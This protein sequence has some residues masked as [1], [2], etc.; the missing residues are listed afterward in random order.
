MNPF[1]TET[2]AELCLR[3]GHRGEGLAIYRRLVASAADPPTRHRLGTRLASLEADPRVGTMPAP[4]PP[5]PKPREKISEKTKEKARERPGGPSPLLTEPG[6]RAS[7]AGDELTI[8]WRLPASTS[9]P[10][11][12]HLLL[13]VKTNAGVVTETRALPLGA[14][15]G[16]VALRVPGL[17][18]VRAAAGY[19]REDRFVPV[20]RAQA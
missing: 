12:L 17:H 8:D 19:R 2:M 1:E 3:Q 14:E 7:A 9:L 13:V 11:E 6:L 20:L 4:S 5:A 15:A 18:S 10:R 16:R